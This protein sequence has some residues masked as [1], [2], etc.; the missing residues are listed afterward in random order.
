MSSM[1]EHAP[2]VAS[3]VVGDAVGSGVVGGEVVGGVD[4]HGEFHHAAVLDHLGRPLGDRQF[5]ATTA[6]YQALLAWLCGFG[7][8]LRVG[9][10][11]TSSYGA[12][13]ARYLRSAGVAMVEVDRP[14][15][16][17]RRRRGKSDPIDAYAAAHTALDS[18][19][20]VIPKAGDGIVESIRALRV[21]R[22]GAV[23]ARTATINQL[24]SL[25]VTAPAEIREPLAGLRTS[26]LVAACAGLAPSGALTDPANAVRLVARRLARRYRF[27]TTEIR[28]ADAELRGLVTAAAP[29]I[30]TRLGVGIEVAGQLLTTVGDN[31]DRMR[32]EAAF[33]HLC[34]VAPIPA[35]SGK[36]RRHR[37]NRG[38]DRAA[39]NALYTVVLARLRLD[40]RT[41]AYV[42]RRTAEGKDRREIIRCLQRFVARELYQALVRLP[43]S[44]SSWPAHRLERVGQP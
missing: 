32:S 26:V 29:G 41:R 37:L 20:V 19:Q 18:A 25:L 38:G 16:R 35:S 3:G 21:T 34:G 28:L 40:E 12:G 31:P 1:T 27:L 24:K 44:S 39:N 2:V 11:G 17:T 6:G 13:L 4:T 8:L 7:R 14:N 22:R 10:E 23:K 30:T 15:R 43:A 36:T 5:P 9:V 33:A 42:A